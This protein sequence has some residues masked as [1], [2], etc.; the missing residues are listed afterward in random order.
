MKPFR[1]KRVSE[2]I[3]RGLSEVFSANRS[4]FSDTLITVTEVRPS[5]DLKY[6]KVW[7][8]VFGEREKRQEVLMTLQGMS[9][10]IRFNLAS[11]IRLKYVPELQFRIDETLDNVDR[12][13]HLLKESGIELSSPKNDQNK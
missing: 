5:R 2:V 8:S 10:R 1:S 3:K 11:R 7:V 9:G 13:D 12:I 4:D 6:A